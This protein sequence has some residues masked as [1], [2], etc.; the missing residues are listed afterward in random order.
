MKFKEDNPDSWQE[1]LE[2]HDMIDN[3]HCS[4]QTIAQRAQTFNKVKKRVICMVCTTFL[5]DI[6]L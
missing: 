5:P 3:M 4:P 1:I 2:V 6:T